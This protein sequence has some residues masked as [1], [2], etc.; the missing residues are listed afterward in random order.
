MSEALIAAGASVIAA[1]IAAYGAIKSNRA[2]K[3]SRPVSNGF[4]GDVRAD[5]TEIRRLVTD[6]LRDHATRGD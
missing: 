2:E 1:G 6:H 4:A 5:L 3:N